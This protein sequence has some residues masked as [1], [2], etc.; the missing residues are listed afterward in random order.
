MP[1]ALLRLL[2]GMLPKLNSMEG[3]KTY[4]G[5]PSQG[6]SPYLQIFPPHEKVTFLLRGLRAAMLE[7]TNLW[8][9][10]MLNISATPLNGWQKLMFAE[11]NLL[12]YICREIEPLDITVFSNI[13]IT[14]P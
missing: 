11:C 4:I 9:L 5:R 7:M 1:E 3:Q 12:D 6:A 10:T 8:M 14:V 2:R 13:I